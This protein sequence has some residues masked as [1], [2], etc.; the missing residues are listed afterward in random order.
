LHCT[1]WRLVWQE[2]L[3]Q[4]RDMKVILMSA[5]VNEAAFSAYFGNCPTLQIPGFTFPVKVLLQL[6]RLCLALQ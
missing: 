3:A 5:T 6:A 1:T 4:R 2:L